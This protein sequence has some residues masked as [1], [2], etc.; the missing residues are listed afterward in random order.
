[1]KLKS[2]DKVLQLT[3]ITFKTNGQESSKAELINKNIN[4]K[5]ESPKKTA[6]V[7]YLPDPSRSDELISSDLACIIQYMTLVYLEFTELLRSYI[8]EKITF[9]Y[10]NKTVV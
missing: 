6:N 2:F 10:K 8:F 4:W 5:G 9:E 3:C 7:K 1:M